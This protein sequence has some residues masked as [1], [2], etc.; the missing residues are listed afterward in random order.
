MAVWAVPTRNVRLAAAGLSRFAAISDDKCRMVRLRSWGR[1][2]T[3][4]APGQAMK[5]RAEPE[6]IE[7]ANLE[8]NGNGREI[9]HR[10]GERGD[11]D[12]AGRPGSSKIL[13]RT[14]K[15]RTRKPRQLS[16]AS[17]SNLGCPPRPATRRCSP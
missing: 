8:R 14:G 11:D 2:G 10:G 4:R 12:L 3:R 6:V 16:S 13:S 7:E 5:G 17:S 15:L 1:A 9:V